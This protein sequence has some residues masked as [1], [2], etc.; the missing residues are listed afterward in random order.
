M[1]TW[2]DFYDNSSEWADSTVLSRISSLKEIGS[3]E[4]VVK[5][6]EYLSEKCGNALI[7]KAR[8]LGV[9][10]A[11]DDIAELAEYGPQ[12]EVVNLIRIAFEKRLTF[13]QDNIDTLCACLPQKDE[14]LLRKID[15]VQMI[16]F[17]DEPDGE[18]DDVEALEEFDEDDEPDEYDDSYDYADTSGKKPGFLERLGIFFMVSD[19]SKKRKQSPKYRIGDR[20]LLRSN[21]QAGY[22]VDVNNGRYDVRLDDG[23]FRDSLSETQIERSLF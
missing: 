7:R 4:E 1:T 16:G 8:A 20:V 10:F 9:V 22:I 2:K 6:S 23:S 13:T 19:A 12:G 15:R 11:P 18:E 5:A 17:F 14:P 21:R 3:A